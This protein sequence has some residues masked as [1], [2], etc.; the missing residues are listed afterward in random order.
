[1][2]EGGADINPG[3]LNQEQLDSLRLETSHLSPKEDAEKKKTIGNA[4]HDLLNVYGNYIRKPYSDTEAAQR[5]LLMDHDTLGTF[6]HEWIKDPSAK[7][8][9]TTQ[10]PDFLTF[11]KSAGELVAG[12]AK[13]LW[14]GYSQQEK[15]YIVQ[16]VGVDEDILK[17]RIDTVYSY[18]TYVHELSHIYQDKRI[19]GLFLELAA[20]YYGFHMQKATHGLMLTN[21]EE[22][23]RYNFYQG[24]IDNYGEDVHKLV[25]GSLVNDGE[26]LRNDPRALKILAEFTPEVERQLFTDMKTAPLAKQRQDEPTHL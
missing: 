7:G 14:E 18:G 6:T 2:S 23:A 15:E 21:T 8:T 22:Q 19:H 4:N 1:M 26:S 10:P 25:F 5:F 16:T 11:S 24:L 9:E 17:K 20:Y 12:S 13:D 3:K